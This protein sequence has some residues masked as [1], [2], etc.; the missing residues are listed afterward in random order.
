[1]LLINA[2]YNVQS[3][4]DVEAICGCVQ[5]CLCNCTMYK[6]IFISIWARPVKS[7]GQR[8]QM[9]RGLA[10]FR[11]PGGLQSIYDENNNFNQFKLQFPPQKSEHSLWGNA[12][13]PYIRKSHFRSPPLF[14][15]N[16]VSSA[17]LAQQQP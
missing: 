15:P 14:H 1:M 4:K 11:D 12:H 2:L 10:I 17:G 7:G 8:G 9:P 16:A 3:S 5:V 6:H 13:V